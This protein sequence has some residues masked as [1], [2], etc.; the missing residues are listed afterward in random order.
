MIALQP[1]SGPSSTIFC[2]TVSST[3]RGSRDTS[4]AGCRCTKRVFQ[5]GIRG[6]VELVILNRC[7]LGGLLLLCT[8]ACQPPVQAS[9]DAE[10]S[11]RLEATEQRLASIETKLD[12]IATK[13]DA[14]T[15]DVEP[16]VEWAVLA[17]VNE[18]QEATRHKELEK[19]R[20]ER[21]ERVQRRDE[22]RGALESSD[23]EGGVPS[24]VLDGAAEGIHCTG[25]ETPK[26]ECRFDR[27][28]L[29]DIL[30]NPAAVASQA[31]VVPSM[32]DGK[33]A[34]FKFYGIRPGSVPKLLG[35]KNGDLLETVNGEAFDSVDQAM[36]LY[37]KFRDST[38]LKLGLV[39][40]GEHLSL[41]IEFED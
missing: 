18:E 28:L 38:T 33:S 37:T 16:V 36:A 31:R 40:K 1:T 30:S 4:R 23:A 13:L 14:V 24:R 41:S 26:I 29:D 8:L 34:G 7:T 12:A 6:I 3:T 17:K 27:A 21:E 22:A 25:F 32:R 35:F 11:A 2:S 5:A 10:L 19:R 15:T 39:R 20:E 9:S